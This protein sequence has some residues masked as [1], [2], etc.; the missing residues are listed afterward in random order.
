MPGLYTRSEFLS[1]SGVALT[2]NHALIA[3]SRR[4][5]HCLLSGVTR[6]PEI[7]AS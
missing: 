3:A 4:A 5:S 2:L 6:P 7:S 1:V